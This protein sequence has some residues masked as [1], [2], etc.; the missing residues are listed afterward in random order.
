MRPYAI[1]S[2]CCEPYPIGSPCPG[3]RGVRRPALLGSP[4]VSEAVPAPR[5]ARSS[6]ARAVGLSISLLALLV[7]CLV[8]YFAAT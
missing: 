5:G 3:C 6:Q 2:E 4:V 8:G 7:F 1:C